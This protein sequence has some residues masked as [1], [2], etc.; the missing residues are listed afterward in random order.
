MSFEEFLGLRSDDK[1]A[2]RCALFERSFFQQSQSAPEICVLFL[3]MCTLFALFE[4]AVFLI[5]HIAVPLSQRCDRLRF[6][7]CFF[8][9]TDS[10]QWEIWFTDGVVEQ[11]FGCRQMLQFRFQMQNPLFDVISVSQIAEIVH[12]R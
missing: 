4:I 11:L 8:L 2:V 10:S 1:F 12:V 5:A 3:T 7:V 9:H 6:D